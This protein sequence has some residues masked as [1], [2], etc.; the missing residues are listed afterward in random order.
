MACEPLVAVSDLELRWRPLSTAEKARARVLLNDASAVL[1]SEVRDL[2]ARLA[3]E[4]P[5]AS[6]DLVRMVLCS[7]VKRAML[8]GEES[9]GVETATEAN[10][11]FSQSVKFTNPDGNLYL[12]KAERKMLGIGRQ[13]AFSI[14]LAPMVRP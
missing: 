1:R 4:P 11:P 3:S 5:T 7:V 13:R 12:T 8:V 2:D 6:S 9:A 14:D 10:G